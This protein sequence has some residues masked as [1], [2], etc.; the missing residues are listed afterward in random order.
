MLNFDDKKTQAKFEKMLTPSSIQAINE[1][2]GRVR[3]DQAKVAAQLLQKGVDDEDDDEEEEG[4]DQGEAKHVLSS[5]GVSSKKKQGNI[6][7]SAK[8]EDPASSKTVT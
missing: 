5:L 7:H 1:I 3:A 2:L 6:F 8:K 4:E